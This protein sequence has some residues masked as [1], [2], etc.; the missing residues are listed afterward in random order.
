MTLSQLVS[1]KQVIPFFLLQNSGHSLRINSR[2]EDSGQQRKMSCYDLEVAFSHWKLKIR[3]STT[4]LNIAGTDI[5]ICKHAL[6]VT[7]F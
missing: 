2:V 4:N 7:L 5:L 3:L 6:I 1:L